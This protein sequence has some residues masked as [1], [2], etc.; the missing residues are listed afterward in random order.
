MLCET[1]VG[2]E[3]G[4]GEEILGFAYLMQNAGARATMPHYGR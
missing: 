2:S 3:L 1:A 4:N